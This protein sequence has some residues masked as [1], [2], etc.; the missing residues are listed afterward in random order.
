MTRKKTILQLLKMQ[1]RYYS[2]TADGKRIITDH[3]LYNSIEEEIYLRQL[4]LGRENK[5]KLKAEAENNPDK[6]ALLKR[7]ECSNSP[8]LIK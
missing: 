3:G 8:K 2:L 7:K 4:E 1:K 6:Q 5:K